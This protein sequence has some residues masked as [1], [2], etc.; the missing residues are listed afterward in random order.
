MTNVERNT[1]LAA[2]YES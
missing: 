2:E 1:A